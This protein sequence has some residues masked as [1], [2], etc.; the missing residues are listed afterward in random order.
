M[1][2]AIYGVLTRFQAFHGN[3]NWKWGRIVSVAQDREDLQWCIVNNDCCTWLAHL[4]VY[5]M[6]LLAWFNRIRQAIVGGDPV[7]QLLPHPAMISRLRQCQSCVLWE[8]GDETPALSLVFSVVQWHHWEGD[9]GQV[10]DWVICSLM[11]CFLCEAQACVVDVV[12]WKPQATQC[13]VWGCDHSLILHSEEVLWKPVVLPC[14]LMCQNSLSLETRVQ[15]G[16]ILTFSEDIDGISSASH[17]GDVAF[18]Y[19]EAHLQKE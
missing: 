13:C 11:L 19:H 4:G 12:Q 10:K 5:P 1:I 8:P 6:S 17:G 2:A 3:W 18:I 9:Y 16:L 14:W 15:T 7:N